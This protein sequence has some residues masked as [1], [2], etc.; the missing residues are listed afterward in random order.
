MAYSAT[1]RIIHKSFTKVNALV[2]FFLNILL[3]FPENRNAQMENCCW[4]S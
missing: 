4:P 1:S 3:L 2:Y